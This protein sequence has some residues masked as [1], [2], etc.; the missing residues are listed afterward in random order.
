MTIRHVIFIALLVVTGAFF[1]GAWLNAWSGIQG[2]FLPIFLIFLA[3]L[4]AHD[5][6]GNRLLPPPN[7]L[8]QIA[9]YLEAAWC[10]ALAAVLL[11]G[12]I[13]S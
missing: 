6:Y 5:A 11:W 1:G 4:V 9:G 7:A 2:I 13:S 10:L 12:H 8:A 3:I